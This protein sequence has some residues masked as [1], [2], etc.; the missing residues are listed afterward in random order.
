MVWGGSRGCEQVV[1]AQVVSAQ[2]SQG[3]EVSLG[4]EPVSP[5]GGAPAIGWLIRKATVES[6]SGAC[7]PASPPTPTPPAGLP[8]NV[9]GPRSPVS[10]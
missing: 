8:A 2:V 4:A 6:P 3:E 10:Q 1:S 7:T 5:A 9:P